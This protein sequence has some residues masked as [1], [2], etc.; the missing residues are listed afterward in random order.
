[1]SESQNADPKLKRNVGVTNAFVFANADAPGGNKRTT[2]KE[3]VTVEKVFDG[4]DPIVSGMNEVLFVYPGAIMPLEKS[5]LEF[6]PLVTTG[7][8]TGAIRVADATKSEPPFFQRE[9]RNKHELAEMERSSGHRYV[10]AARIQGKSDDT[11][12]EKMNVVFV[13][14]ID[15]LSGGFISMRQ[16]RAIGMNLVFQ[17]VAFVLNVIDALAGDDRFLS[18]RKDEVKF[19]KLTAVEDRKEE[20]RKAADDEEDG[21][22]KDFRNKIEDLQLKQDEI[23]TQ[24][25]KVEKDMQ[26]VANFSE[27]K[28]LFNERESLQTSLKNTEKQF[29]YDRVRESRKRDEA[30]EQRKDELE[31][32]LE[33]LEEHYK[34]LAVVLPP[35]PPLLVAIGVYFSR[36]AREKEGVSKRRLR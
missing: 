26:T 27:Q 33:Q 3:D 20:S 5:K 25:D 12:P 4:K 30:I 34:W 10:L 8:R 21:Y 15:P 24:I 9:M 17:N 28:K 11:K 7:D 13:A 2:I 36:R 22:R 14:D 29:V 16:Q 19:R 6:R 18:L 35:I 23:Q 32:E 1:M 31:T